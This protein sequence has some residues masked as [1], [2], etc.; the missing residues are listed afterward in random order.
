MSRINP[1][2]KVFPSDVFYQTGIDVRTYIAT[3][4]M[5]GSIPDPGADVSTVKEKAELAVM[6]ADALINELNKQKTTPYQP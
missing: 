5:A 4:L 1:S 2:D 6:A 3:R